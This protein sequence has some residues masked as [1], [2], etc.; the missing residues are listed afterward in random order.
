MRWFF[1]LLLLVLIAPAN[2]QN[3]ESTY[4]CQEEFMGGIAFNG[5]AKEW[6][7]AVFSTRR[8]FILKTKP[9]G[10]I[11][12]GAQARSIVTVTI[13]REGG[14]IGVECLDLSQEVENMAK[15]SI[16]K[17][18]IFR[19]TSSATEYHVNRANNRFLTVYAYGYVNGV[20]NNDDT[21][22]V[23]GGKCTKIN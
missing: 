13:T 19:C 20:D 2:G 15:V 18:N 22:F 12:E 9:A 3:E 17:N 1:A 10:L 23:S 8:N 21:P 5:S 14:S 7:G 16:Q 6:E 4:F 11:G